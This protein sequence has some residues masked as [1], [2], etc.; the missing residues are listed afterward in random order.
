MVGDLPGHA[1]A[2]GSGPQVGGPGRTC[3]GVRPGLEGESGVSINANGQRDCSVQVEEFQIW[4]G[5]GPGRSRPAGRRYRPSGPDRY[6]R[7]KGQDQQWPGRHR[8][9]A[10]GLTGSGP[11]R[12]TGGAGLAGPGVPVLPEGPTGPWSRSETLACS[13][14]RKT[15]WSVAAVAVIGLSPSPRARGRR[16]LV[17]SL[18]VV[19]G[20]PEQANA[21]V[22]AR[23]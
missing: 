15:S 21:G 12:R 2:R 8:P 6:R 19:A 5:Y 17:R 20:S 22:G 9:A 3:A 14:T 23:R 18:P 10:Q 11:A 7:G 1:P 16:C 4:A 13:P